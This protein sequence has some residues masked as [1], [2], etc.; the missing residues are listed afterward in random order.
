MYKKIV[1][2]ECEYHMK[3][4]IPFWGE[5]REEEEEKFLFFDD[6]IFFIVVASFFYIWSASDYLPKVIFFFRGKSF[7]KN[8]RQDESRE[9][10][11]RTK[12][13]CTCNWWWL[14]LYYLFLI[15]MKGLSSLQ[16]PLYSADM[17]L[18]LNCISFSCR[19]SFGTE[20]AARLVAAFYEFR[21]MK[22]FFPAIET[23]RLFD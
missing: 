14:T 3:I 19:K 18:G 20:I 17:Q 23:R 10:E 4:K 1:F 7:L 11:N 8:R 6:A 12:K 22:L 15:C 21:H 13:S 16:W 5:Q 9:G 2:W